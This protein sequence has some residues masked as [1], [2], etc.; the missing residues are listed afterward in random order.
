MSEEHPHSSRFGLILMLVAIGGSAIAVF[1]WHFLSNRNAG[2]DT[3]GF[4]MSATI[5]TRRP[6]AVAP[7]TAAPAAQSSLMVKSEA[8]MSALNPGASTPAATKDAGSANAKADPALTLKDALIQNEQAARAYILRM[9]AQY[10]SIGQYGRDWMA[11]PEL[12]ALRDQ[13]WKDKDPIKFAYGVAKSD[14]FGPLVK[15]YARDPGIRA[16]LIGAVK[17]APAGLIK[18]VGGA[19]SGNTVVKEL[20]DTVIQAVGLPASLVSVLGGK[21]SKAPD[22][23]Q[24]MTDIMSSPDV[25]KSLNNQQ[26]PVSL[27]QKD[28][29]KAKESAPNGFRP[30]GGR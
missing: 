10:P 21:D 9:Q 20:V 11:N 24:I 7:V 12:R 3:S 29:D 26:S 17:E 2:L 18:A 15:K 19:V 1:G 4:D 13:Y 23:N 5:D 14:G 16:V 22:T 8:G 25:K 6:M 27:D 30:L 28:I